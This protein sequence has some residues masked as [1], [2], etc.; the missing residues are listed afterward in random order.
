MQYPGKALIFLALITILTASCASIAV[1]EKEDLSY[2]LFGMIY[3]GSG[4]PVAGADVRIEGFFVVELK[5]DSRG[6]WEVPSFPSGPIHVV[7]QKSGFERIEGDFLLDQNESMVYTRLLSA[8]DLV[9]MALKQSRD[10]DWTSAADSIKRAR[11]LDPD[12]A[13]TLYAAG[14]VYIK[15][16]N[17]ELA[18]TVI[19][20]LL[21][22]QDVYP[23]VYLLAAEWE[24]LFSPVTTR[25][26]A[27][28]RSYLAV[29]DDKKIQD[30]LEKIET[31]TKR[32]VKE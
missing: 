22:M 3:D 31:E 27:W 26:I 24:S 23:A 15:Q 18:W 8:P 21:A 32:E 30:A 9:D 5:S 29:R 25:R 20:Q 28:Y 13:E 17:G 4:L 16:G 1:R 2:R 6:R 11:E 12:G 10:E 14:I 19:E 7:V